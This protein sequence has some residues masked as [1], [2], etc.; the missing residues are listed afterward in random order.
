MAEV[1]N[2]TP[3]SPEAH[4]MLRKWHRAR[5]RH[6]IGK[7]MEL[8]GYALG[9]PYVPEEA[10]DTRLQSRLAAMD[11][12]RKIDEITADLAGDKMLYSREWLRYKV[13]LYLGVSNFITEEKKMIYGQMNAE[14]Q[15]NFRKG[16]ALVETAERA[17]ERGWH[18]Q[19]EDWSRNPGR[20]DSEQLMGY[21][22]QFGRQVG[23]IDNADGDGSRTS[24]IT[25]E[26]RHKFFT[27]L[28][29]DL[30]GKRPAEAAK[31]IA[32]LEHHDITR[33]GALHI[34]VRE[35]LGLFEDDESLEQSKNPAY[36]A[37]STSVS[38]WNDVIDI[39]ARADEVQRRAEDID[40]TWLPKLEQG[41]DMLQAGGQEFTHQAIKEAMEQRE[42]LF[43]EIQTTTSIIGKAQIMAAE[44]QVEYAD[45]RMRSPERLIS[46]QEIREQTRI[47]EE[48]PVAG[49]TPTT[50]PLG[51]GTPVSPPTGA[52]P[53][54]APLAG[55]PTGAPTGAPAQ[56]APMGGGM[57]TGA[58]SAGQLAQGNLTQTR[59]QVA[60]FIEE[61]GQPSHDN[62]PAYVQM[63]HAILSDKG[64]QERIAE[65]KWENVPDA[66][67]FRWL[68]QDIRK[69]SDESVQ[70]A[71]R[72][73]AADPNRPAHEQLKAKARLYGS[74]DYDALFPN[75]PKGK[76]S[77]N[78]GS[79]LTKVGSGL[80]KKGKEPTEEEAA[81]SRAEEIDPGDFKSLGPEEDIPA[82][83]VTEEEAKE[84]MR[85]R[86]LPD[87]Q[88]QVNL[89][90]EGIVT[91]DPD[92]TLFVLN[93]TGYWHDKEGGTTVRVSGDKSG[94][95][96]TGGDGKP[97]SRKS[98]DNWILEDFR[99][100]QT[101][102]LYADVADW[103]DLDKPDI[104]EGHVP[105]GERGLGLEGAGGQ[106]IADADAIK[107]LQELVATDPRFQV[108]EPR[109]GQPSTGEFIISPE[110]LE[111]LT[112]RDAK[113]LIKKR[114][115][116]TGAME[117]TDEELD[118]AIAYKPAG[119][120]MRDLGGPETKTPGITYDEAR[121]NALY[122]QL[123]VSAEEDETE[124]E[125]AEAER[126]K[127]AGALRAGEAIE[128]AAPFTSAKKQAQALQTAAEKRA[129]AYTDEEQAGNL[130]D[131]RWRETQ[132]EMQREK[133]KKKA[134]EKEFKRQQ[135]NPWN[136]E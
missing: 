123:G 63:R 44:R 118:A 107:Q 117:V 27:K 21:T 33:P 62:D 109:M 73:I 122:G 20:T 129:Q 9:D 22:T 40:N 80:N 113:E 35:E 29:A 30:A 24:I 66:Q 56:A 71:Y 5:R 64:I 108:G 110:E 103:E 14:D 8:G 128:M 81:A 16:S 94:Q 102:S 125:F 67:R 97:L 115:A 86:N 15:L 96:L 90:K 49:V 55:A 111:G 85:K 76:G 100:N 18:A 1:E 79:L 134:E 126:K 2:Q 119:T 133:Q 68:A 12:L 46:S 75:R 25:T 78:I 54:T 51:T 53:A 83:E 92:G 84:I 59:D 13:D 50:P 82:G 58:L 38:Y 131:S 91:D 132:R 41:S 60:D 6:F 52:P 116:A 136:I 57:L 65:N 121:R 98:I 88:A 31:F 3:V 61:L 130:M 89:D 19:F 93:G 45:G 87:L 26:D 17:L 120:E 43:D 23:D 124:A 104:T 28:I 7:G 42:A 39:I 74:G 48:V 69:A 135:Q 72:G 4:D 99:F 36:K 34:N 101:G 47:E 77:G 32:Q 11:L 112:Y 37:L 10:D 95:T 105:V 106:A 70:E 127:T 114:A